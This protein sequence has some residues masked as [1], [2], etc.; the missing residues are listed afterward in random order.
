[1]C[2]AT[3]ILKEIYQKNQCI[4]E[5]EKELNLLNSCIKAFLKEPDDIERYGDLILKKLELERSIILLLHPISLNNKP[6]ICPEW[7]EIGNLNFKNK[8]PQD[9]K[10]ELDLIRLRKKTNKTIKKRH[11]SKLD[12]SS[13][14]EK[15]GLVLKN[16]FILCP[17][18]VERNSSC[19]IYFHT[20]T[21]YCFSCNKWGTASDL[22]DALGVKL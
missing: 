19:K 10:A 1:M 18:H 21:F 12:I 3:Y 6:C 5:I 17:F 4:Y 14:L 20:N 16:G 8:P 2:V 9:L 13:V 11:G 15:A 22:A 7:D